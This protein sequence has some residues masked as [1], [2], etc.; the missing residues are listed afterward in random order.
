MYTSVAIPRSCPHHHDWMRQT[1]GRGLGCILREL[2]F[3][4]CT[5]LQVKWLTL[6][7][8]LSGLQKKVCSLWT[9]IVIGQKILCEGRRIYGSV[10]PA[11]TKTKRMITVMQP[12]RY[13]FIEITSLPFEVFSLV[14]AV[15][16]CAAITPWN[17]PAAMI[18]RKAWNLNCAFSSNEAKLPP[19]PSQLAPALATGCSMIVKPAEDTPL[20]ALAIQTLA[21]ILQ[22]L[23]FHSPPNFDCRFRRRGWCAAWGRA[24]THLVAQEYS[25]YW[26][27]SGVYILTTIILICCVRSALCDSFT[28][29]KLSFTGFCPHH[30]L[31]LLA[32]TSVWVS[33]STQVGKILA[34]QCA[35]TV[36][37]VSLELGKWARVENL[38]RTERETKDENCWGR[39]I[40]A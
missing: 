12:G 23:S 27:R 10:I 1:S 31:N 18:T 5:R 24:Y 9:Q 39:T 13:H 2:R 4:R 26:D 6:P 38:D 35:S 34:A 17:F 19:G 28:V 3:K 8:S 30:S 21:G 7:L 15:G 16:V 33:R 36:K 29:R 14:L 37:R 22:I 11:N 25:W 40:F 32:V 20:S